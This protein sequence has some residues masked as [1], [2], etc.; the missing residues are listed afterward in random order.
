MSRVLFMWA[1]KQEHIIVSIVED[2]WLTEIDLTCIYIITC[3]N[4]SLAAQVYPFKNGL[5]CIMMLVKQSQV[6]QDMCFIV[7]TAKHNITLFLASA[8]T[9]DTGI[10]CAYLRLFCVFLKRSGL[11]NACV[12]LVSYKPG[13]DTKTVNWQSWITILEL[14]NFCPTREP[15]CNV[16]MI[17]EQQLKNSMSWKVLLTMLLLPTGVFCV[18]LAVLL[19]FAEVFRSF[20]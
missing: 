17:V 20:Q 18:S 6:C 13:P 9:V 11:E 19:C 4:V 3:L 15:S 14:S 7:F 8:K 2:N 10:S 5:N 12:H 16:D 1:W